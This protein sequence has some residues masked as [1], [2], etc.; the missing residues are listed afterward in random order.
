MGIIK[1]RASFLGHVRDL[2]QVEYVHRKVIVFE[3]ICLFDENKKSSSIG[4]RYKRKKKE[5]ITQLL[6]LYVL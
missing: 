3:K 5:F 4:N 1:V 2:E 6:V